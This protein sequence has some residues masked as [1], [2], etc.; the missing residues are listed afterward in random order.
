MS[1]PLTG[2]DDPGV[3]TIACVVPG[4][5]KV[6]NCVP[7]DNAFPGARAVVGGL[8]ALGTFVDGILLANALVPTPETDEGLTIPPTAVGFGP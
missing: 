8:L 2:T 7:L 1:I 4:F 3:K 5:V 6:A